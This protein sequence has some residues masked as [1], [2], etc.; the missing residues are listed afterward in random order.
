[1]ND[2]SDLMLDFEIVVE[3]LGCLEHHGGN[4]QGNSFSR[5]M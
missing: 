1:M 2:R 5:M 3:G 4:S